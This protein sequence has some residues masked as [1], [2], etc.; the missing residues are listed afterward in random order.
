MRL[1]QRRS[2]GSFG[3]TDNFVEQVPKYAILSHTWLAENEEVNFDDMR[4]GMAWR[5]GPSYDK[6]RF[7]GTQ[8]ARDGLEYFWVDTCCIDRS[9]SAELQEATI[10]MFR[11]YRRSTRC[12]VYLMDVSVTEEEVN[13]PVVSWRW[14]AAFRDSRWFTRGWTLQE[15]IAP[16]YVDFFS[17]Q[18]T[19][20]G[21]KQSL[22]KCIHETT[23]IP[24]SALQGEHLSNF[25][26]SERLSWA[27]NRQTT[28]KEDKA[29]SMLGM[30][31]IFMPLMY[32]E[33]DHAFTR[34]QDEIDK[35]HSGNAELIK[36]LDTLPTAPQAAFNSLDNQHA[37]TCLPD[38]RV[39]LLQDITRWADGLHG[40]CIFWL[41][42]IAGTGKSTVAR[43]IARKYHDQGNLGGSF[44][45]SR[46]GGDASHADRLFITLA[47]QLA[48]EIPSVRPYIREAIKE[49]K[50]IALQ[51]L[52]DQWNRLI[53]GPFSK[54]DS[55]SCPP[56]IVLVLDA[57]DECDSERDI[58]IIF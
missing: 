18:G 13:G 31:S 49:H 44:F 39:E 12:Y 2:D 8:A 17:I 24:L 51:S 16:A 7:C 40:R 15:L 6:I 23:G 26:V 47:S 21:D 54:L 10:A 1:L 48:I 27:S 19:R 42:G 45:F 22:Q 9:S 25:S 5:K 46:G 33:G 28:R 37:T 3:L 14:E 57:L 55:D 43:T 50:D 35:S 53:I 11:W 30:F 52:R 41:N 56:S 20:L 32:G 38:T 29:Y 34:L 4:N 36:L 58:R